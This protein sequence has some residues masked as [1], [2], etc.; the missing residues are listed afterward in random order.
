MSGSEKWSREEGL[1]VVQKP[2]MHVVEPGGESA[3]DTVGGSEAAGTE[4]DGYF[5]K[6]L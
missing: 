1:V 6:A 4:P 2:I 3:P 5:T